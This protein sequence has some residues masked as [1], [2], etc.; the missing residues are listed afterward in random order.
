MVAFSDHVLVVDAPSSAATI[1]DHVTTLA[2]G[3]PIRYVVPTHHHDDHASGVGRFVAAGATVVTTAAARTLMERL[4]W[5]DSAPMEVLTTD[6][7]IFTDGR[8]TVEIHNIGSGP[9]AED[10]LVA[11]IPEEGILFQA[12]LI[13]GPIGGILGPGANNET[14]MHFAAWLKGKNW[15]VE[16]YAGSHGPLPSPEAFEALITTPIM[17]LR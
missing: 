7:R 8:R 17:P 12:D 5:T 10:M 2:P 13:E 11:W 4:A 9:H 6:L 1:I 15:P 3:K 16:V 14:T